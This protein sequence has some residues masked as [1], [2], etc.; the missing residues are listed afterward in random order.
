[1]A[2]TLP[3][4]RN[5]VEIL[6]A[7]DNTELSDYDIDEL[8]RSAVERYSKDAPD[9]STDDVTGDDG[10]YYDITAQLSSWVEGFSR[11]E[12]IEYPAITVA[13]DEVPVYLDDEDWRDDYWA[14]GT[15]YLFL[16]NHSPAAT[17]TM[18]IKYTIPYTWTGSPDQTNTPTQDFYAICNLAAGLCC[19]SI[20]AKY[21]RSS[22]STMA[23]DSVNHMTRAQEFARR[24]REFIGF[25]N[26][27]MGLGD[28]GSAFQP[29]AGD[30]VDLD[31][32]PGWP[33]G[34]D[35]LFH[36]KETR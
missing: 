32:A 23:A 20:A 5:Q 33:I 30:F 27:H 29:A 36:G 15:R 16:P 31:T 22:D 35:Y 12:E 2:T 8:V 18:R 1:M 10:R 6:L 34:R 24:A 26:E 19:Q 17:E 28:D 25:Y 21:S 13:D 9:D 3:T 7:D 4:F 11:I 14:G